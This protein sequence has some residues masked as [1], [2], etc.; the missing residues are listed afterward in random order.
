[1]VTTLNA[2][3]AVISSSEI[4][5]QEGDDAFRITSSVFSD[6][7]NNSNSDT[8]TSAAIKKDSLVARDAG[9][10]K[11]FITALSGSRT[12][13]S[14]YGVNGSRVEKV[15]MEQMQLLSKRSLEAQTEKPLCCSMPR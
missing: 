3:V 7:E 8:F 11:L 6:N 1:M 13:S 10:D 2:E 9:D 14:A 5:G 15:A 12:T 4:R